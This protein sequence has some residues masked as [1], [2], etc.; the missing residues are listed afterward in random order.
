[1]VR[2]HEN[3]L[4][5]YKELYKESVN[6]IGQKIKI[7]PNLPT[8]IKAGYLNCQIRPYIPNPLRCFKCQRFGHSQTS[9]RGQ[10]TCSRCA[11]VG[12]SSTDCTLEPKCTNCLQS[13]ASNL[14]LCRKWKLEKQIQEI[15]AN[16]NISFSEARKVIVP[17]A[18]Q[19]YAQITKPTV[20]S[21]SSQTDSSITKISCPPLQCLSPISSTS[22]SIPTV[23][24]SSS[25]AQAHLLP[26]PSAI[27]PS[28]QSESLLKIPIPTTTTSPGNNLNTS[29]LSLET[30]TRSLT[31]SNKFAAL[32]NETQ[33]LVPLPE[34]VPT[35]SNSEHSNASEIPEC[36]TKSKK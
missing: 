36:K 5:L 16:K 18:S 33:Q 22:S 15:E 9:C 28:I 14:K 34:S 13:H 10:L 19:T 6:E 26:S 2:C 35:T 7:C 31:T 17:Q 25:L 29:V 4:L 23:S 27:M 1:M 11:S 20:I 24:T 21:T 32:S 30:E 12:H 8:S 3:L